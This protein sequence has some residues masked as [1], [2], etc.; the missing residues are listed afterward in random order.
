LKLWEEKGLFFR[1]KLL[2]ER[3]LQEKNLSKVLWFTYGS[4]DFQRAKRLKKEGMLVD[5]IEI[6]EM[7]KIFNFRF[8]AYIYSL[9]LPFLYKKELQEADIYKTNQTDGSWSAVIAKKLYAKKLLYRTGFTISDLENKLKRFSPFIL[10]SIEFFESL[11]YKNCDYAVV[12]SQHNLTYVKKK[13]RVVSQKIEVIYNYI[14]RDRFYD[15]EQEREERVVFIGRLSEEKNIF[16]LIEATEEVSLKLDIYGSGPLEQTL[17]KFVKQRG[18]LGVTFKGNIANSE[19][20][21]V[22][23]A[24]KYFALVSKYEGMPKAL[25]EGM[26]CGAIVIGTDVNGINEVIVNG[27]GLLAKDISSH[28]IAKKL[29]EAQNLQEKEYVELKQRA[30]ENIEKYFTL[31]S[32]VEKEMRIFEDLLD[33]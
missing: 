12:A 20:P 1:E 8:G 19:L 24:V 2:Y 4:D 3:H 13:Y 16:H 21:Q 28:E 26:S 18:Y 32:V 29:K 5:D 7:P 33:V 14:D 22:L 11:A 6:F 27:T 25:I 31:T 30:K 23:N 9:V 17:K 15:F 10:K